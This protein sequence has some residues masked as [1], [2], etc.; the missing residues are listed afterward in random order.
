MATAER[1]AN[2]HA[3]TDMNEPS[4]TGGQGGE[5]AAPPALN[6][7]EGLASQHTS[8]LP[9]LFDQLRISLLVTTYQAGKL[10][11][12]RKD[13]A[14]LNTHFRHFSK[15]MGLAADRNRLAIGT[16]QEI[17]EYRNIPAICDK[18]QP[19]GR[20]DACYVARSAWVTG[21]IDIHEMAFGAQDRLWFI[22]TRFS[23][24]CTLDGTHSFVPQWRP[25]FVRA[26][27]PEDRC[28]LNGLGM[29]DARPRY[30]TALGSSDTP[31]GW[32]ER[33]K[34]GGVLIDIESGRTICDGLSMPHSPRWYADQLWVLESGKGSLAKVDPATGKLQTVIELPGFTRGIDFYGP[35]A[36]IGLSQVRETAVFSGIPITER[37]TQ[38][39]SGVYVVNIMTGQLVGYLRFTAGV[40]EIFSV[41]VLPGTVY[42]EVLEP[43]DGLTGSAYVLPDDAL[44]DVPAPLVK[45][46]DT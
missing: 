39:N 1:T 41:S 17:I 15:P 25:K 18:L 21:N 37:E 20:H 6:T 34:D 44:K 38:R 13:G 11:V 8:N 10:I 12:V 36:F 23:S 28:H 45:G 30:V 35:L 16:T 9:Q 31:Q 19:A 22:N 26:L 40:Q 2:R 5:A 32:R 33:K 14:V 24:L 42:P 29:R 3:K 46:S 4:A 7:P 43:A 27:A